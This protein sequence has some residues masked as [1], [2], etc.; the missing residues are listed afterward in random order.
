MEC[1]DLQAVRVEG[2]K[3]SGWGER[4]SDNILFLERV[5]V[6]MKVATVAIQALTASSSTITIVPHQQLH[7]AHPP[8]R[9]KGRLPFRTRETH[10]HPRNMWSCEA[11]GVEY[12]PGYGVHGDLVCDV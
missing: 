9:V 7:C 4:C 10:S 3:V 12:P 5:V 6:G 1:S 8:R 11:G 2:L